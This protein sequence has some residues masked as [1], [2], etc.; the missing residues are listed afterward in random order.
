[1]NN[2]QKSCIITLIVCDAVITIALFIICLIIYGGSLPAGFFAI[3]LMK[4]IFCASIV[5]LIIL[6]ACM[7]PSA[8]SSGPISLFYGIYS[9]VIASGFLVILI[10]NVLPD[11]Q[12]EQPIAFGAIIYHGI[13]ASMYM[14]GLALSKCRR[15][16]N[17]EEVRPLVVAAADAPPPHSEA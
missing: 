17:A 5:W 1:M 8:Q 3:F 10:L 14:I 12:S 4:V 13:V 11:Y 7:E 2:T 16:G 9:T 15:R 6:E